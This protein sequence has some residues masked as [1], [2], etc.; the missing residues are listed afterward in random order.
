MKRRDYARDWYRPLN[1]TLEIFS[2][3][4]RITQKQTIKYLFSLP[5][6]HVLRSITGDSLFFAR[7]VEGSAQ[8][9]PV[10]C[11]A[12]RGTTSEKTGEYLMK[13]YEQNLQNYRHFLMSR[14]SRHETGGRQSSQ[15]AQ[16]RISCYA[17]PSA[18]L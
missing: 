13:L 14:S 10:L 9:K 3:G 2:D 18:T 4:E 7:L 12:W 11:V 1:P 15:Q 5:L 8:M 6:H 17:Y 16:F